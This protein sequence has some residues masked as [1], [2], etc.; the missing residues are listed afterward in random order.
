MC[1]RDSSLYCFIIYCSCYNYLLSYLWTNSTCTPVS[2]VLLFQVVK[3]CRF[4]NDVIKIHTVVKKLFSYSL[5]ADTA[6]CF[7]ATA[8][9][10][11]VP[12][13]FMIE[14]TQFLKILNA[15]FLYCNDTF[16]ISLRINPWLQYEN[17]LLYT[18]PFVNF[19]NPHHYVFF[20]T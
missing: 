11:L 10:K 16:S 1:I 6:K 5:S 9:L 13:K 19:C 3:F 15:N 4:C 14:K 2:I 20:V 17:C 12:Q 8:I 7:Q 18:S